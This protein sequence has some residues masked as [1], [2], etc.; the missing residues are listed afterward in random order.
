MSAHYATAAVMRQLHRRLTEHDYAIL[1]SVSELRFV[2]GSQLTRMHFAGG[3]DALASARAARRALLRLTHL[4]CLERLPRQVGGARAGS[5]GFVY[6]L[7]LAGQR[8]AVERGW[9]PKRRTR[10]S[11]TPG[12][13]F[14]AHALQ[15]AELH[16][17][18]TEADRSRR[19]ELLE[20]RAEP[21]CWRS[22]GGVGAK[23][24]VLKPDSYLRLG[25]GEYE[26]S[27]FIE[28]DM[29]T[30]GS[31]AIE[32]QLQRYL[33]YAASGVEQ[34]ERG[35]FPKVLWLVP[36]GQREGVI[37]AAIGRLPGVVRELFQAALFADIMRVVSDT[38]NEEN[39]HTPPK[40]SDR[41]VRYNVSNTS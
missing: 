36:D 2:T 38:S 37:G 13:S 33:D 34:A 29:G 12:T 11:Q 1:R 41:A 3:F 20:L 8:L 22:Y 9:Q 31:R 40:V 21:A 17:L 27:Y 5:A 16:T 25:A 28:V 26:D 32:R 39:S 4:G 6:R 23:S 15:V 30:E 19:V 18:L 10:R 24:V 7:G 14:L 35:V